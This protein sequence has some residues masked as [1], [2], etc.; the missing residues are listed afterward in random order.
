[1]E[2]QDFLASSTSGTQYRR[3]NSTWIIKIEKLARAWYMYNS[4][5]Y[6]STIAYTIN[7]ASVKLS[8]SHTYFHVAYTYVHPL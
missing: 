8:H 4:R 7:S 2:F 3:I 5:I 1:M 6:A